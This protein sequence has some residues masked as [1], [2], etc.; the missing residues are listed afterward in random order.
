MPVQQGSISATHVANQPAAF[1]P[2]NLGMRSGDCRHREAQ[3]CRVFTP[4][5][6]PRLRKGPGPRELFELFRVKQHQPRRP[7]RTSRV[8]TA[9]DSNL[10]HCSRSAFCHGGPGFVG[11]SNLTGDGVQFL[12]KHP[13][14][15]RQC[16]FAN[17][18]GRDSILQPPPKPWPS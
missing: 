16:N 3:V 6:N 12:S 13:L 7:P 9:W 14:V 15:P 8:R 1:I 10:L 5:H 11:M 17:R 18:C 4:N 2:N